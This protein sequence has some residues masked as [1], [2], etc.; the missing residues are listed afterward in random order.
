MTDDALKLGV[1]L[2]VPVD[3]EILYQPDYWQDRADDLRRLAEALREDPDFYHGLNHQADKLEGLARKALFLKQKRNHWM[4]RAPKYTFSATPLPAYTD[5][6]F[7]STPK[8]PPAPE[9]EDR[10]VNL[11]KR[12]R[13]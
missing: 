13:N 4:R 5:V 12:K 10:V 8:S 7:V 2:G 6:E 1:S 3:K 9:F 11:V